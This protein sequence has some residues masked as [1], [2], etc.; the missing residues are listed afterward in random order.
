MWW[1]IAVRR[2]FETIDCVAT[3]SGAPRRGMAGRYSRP[4]RAEGEFLMAATEEAESGQGNE[5]QES[6]AAS[7]SQENG[8]R[9]SSIAKIAGVAVGVGAA[10][11]AGVFAG[12]RLFSGRGESE[13]GEGDE[14][15]PG[16]DDAEATGDAPDSVATEGE[17]RA[18]V[19][20]EDD[21]APAVEDEG[22]PD[23][24]QDESASDETVEE[25]DANETEARGVDSEEDDGETLAAIPTVLKEAAVAA[26]EAAAR[27]ASEVFNERTAEQMKDR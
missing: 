18:D 1:G 2:G 13:D 24:Q 20:G 3:V 10:V 7:Q 25:G 22:R 26:V 6:E 21:A 8:A 4:D 15:T 14:A 9:G 12:R 17:A 11:A 27:A 23:A 19:E 16:A 5:E